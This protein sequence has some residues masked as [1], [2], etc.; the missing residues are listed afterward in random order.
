LQETRAKLFRAHNL[1]QLRR[2]FTAKYYTYAV[3]GLRFRSAYDESGCL[4]FAEKRE[5]GGRGSADRLEEFDADEVHVAGFLLTLYAR[6]N[7]GHA[8]RD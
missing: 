1:P 7:R 4:N 3:L 5:A 2:A 6:L 8:S